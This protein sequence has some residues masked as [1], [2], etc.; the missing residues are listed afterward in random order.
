MALFKVEATVSEVRVAETLPPLLSVRTPRNDWLL[1]VTSDS[2]FVV[3]KDIVI[4]VVCVLMSQRTKEPDR[5]Q[6]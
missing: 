4:I 1:S 5:V 6:V 3:D 2:V